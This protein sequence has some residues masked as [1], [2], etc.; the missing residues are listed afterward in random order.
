[1]PDTFRERQHG[2]VPLH[3]HSKHAA[4]LDGHRA[5]DPHGVTG[6]WRGGGGG[7]EIT[8]RPVGRTGEIRRQPQTVPYD[9]EQDYGQRVEALDDLAERVDLEE[10]GWEPGEGPLEHESDEYSKLGMV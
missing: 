4:T 6:P 8:A 7:E 9:D 2:R 3:M 1:M 5:D 10:Q